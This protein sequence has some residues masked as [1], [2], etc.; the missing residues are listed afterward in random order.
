D[1]GE[2]DERQVDRVE[3]QLD[4]HEHDDRVS[5]DEHAE[6]ADREQHGGQ[7]EVVVGA[8]GSS[9]RS[10]MSVCGRARLIWRYSG[11]LVTA[12]L[13]SGRSAGVSTASWSAYT[14]GP[15]SGAS[16]APP[17]STRS[18]IRSRWVRLGVVRSRC[19]ST[20]APSP[21]VMSSALVASNA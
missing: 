20:I 3:H 19:A 18:S 10:T 4:A 8:H 14:P 17:R 6:R 21:A 12:T 2:R 9:S 13:P 16:C 15:G 1:P 11:T 7:V 5:P